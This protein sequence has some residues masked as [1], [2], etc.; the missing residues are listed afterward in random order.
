MLRKMIGGSLALGAA[1][2]YSLWEAR[3][4][5]FQTHRLAGREGAPALSVLH[6]SDLHLS[7]R[8]DGRVRFVRS[9]ADRLEREPDLV[10]A[11]GDLIEDDSGIDLALEALDPFTAGIGC[12]YVLGSHDY[13]QARFKSPT[14]YLKRSA[15][16]VAAPHADTPRLEGGLEKAGWVALHNRSQHVVTPHGA[17]TVTGV[18]DPYLGRHRT[19][20][21]ERSPEDVFALGLTHAPDVVSEYALAGFDLVLAGHTHGGQLRLP[22]VG[23]LVTNST[24]PAALA[25][26][27]SRIGE[28]WLHVSPGVGT[29]K[30]TPVRFLARPEVTLL[31]MVTNS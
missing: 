16:R 6:I 23:A 13:Y 12:F 14:K 31:E 19:E 7:G 29:S 26:G 15:T 4:Y 24:L 27:P 5:R 18:D 28:T 30:F 20:H 9:V 1:G 3:H 17:I 8:D 21:I 22:F 2:A 10:I 11:T 25:M